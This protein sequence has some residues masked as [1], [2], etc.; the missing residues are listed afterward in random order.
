MASCGRKMRDHSPKQCEHLPALVASR[1][2]NL[3]EQAAD[4]LSGADRVAVL[5]VQHTTKVGT[6]ARRPRVLAG[7]EAHLRPT[8]G[9]PHEQREGPAEALK[10]NAKFTHKAAKVQHAHQCSSYHTCIKG[11]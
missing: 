3:P 1:T 2:G 8:C 6:A 11:E 5:F 9:C 10:N 4:H 7:V